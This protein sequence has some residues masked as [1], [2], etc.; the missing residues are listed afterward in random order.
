MKYSWTFTVPADT[1]E[2]APYTK[3]FQ[4]TH[5][6]LTQVRVVMP[7]GC[8]N[9]VRLRLYWHEFQIAPINTD[10]YLSTD[11]HPIEYPE[12]IPFEAAPYVVKAEA[13]NLDTSNDHDVTLGLVILP[14]S[15]VMSEEKLAQVFTEFQEQWFTYFGGGVPF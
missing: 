10:G 9:N 12:F 13:W 6:I 15:Y 8:L 5:G 1:P 2:T 4:V 7:S 3:E 11:G 14:R